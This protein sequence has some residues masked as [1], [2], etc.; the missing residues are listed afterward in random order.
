MDYTK[1]LKQDI[2]NAIPQEIELRL[3]FLCAV[4]K[5]R[6]A[7]DLYRKSVV[8]SYEFQDKDEALAILDLVKEIGGGEVFFVQKSLNGEKYYRLELKDGD[9]NSLLEKLRLSRY[10]DGVFVA[11]DG[12]DYLNS[13]ASSDALYA[14]L[15]VILLTVGRLKFPDEEYSNYSLQMTFS[16]CRYCEAVKARLLDCGI[17]LKESET[18]T[19]FLLQSRNSAEIEDMLAMCSASDCVF[20]LNNILARREIDNEF[21]RKSNFYMANYKKTVEGAAKYIAAIERLQKSGVLQRQDEKTQRVAAARAENV[22]DSMSE[23]ALKLNISKTGLSRCLNKL[24]E[25][26]EEVENG[27]K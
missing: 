5:N 21:N 14:Y 16:D 27:R 25:L 9:A 15:K 12:V 11:D 1:V 17:E 10:S 8:L 13:L 22:E 20:Q 2:L 26:A 19:S 6:A 23:L 7:I 3:A 18:K 4:T 24:L